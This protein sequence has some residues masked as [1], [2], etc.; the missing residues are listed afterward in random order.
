MH[1]CQAVF[2]NNDLSLHLSLIKECNMLFIRNFELHQVVK[3]IE[4]SQTSLPIQMQLMPT[5]I[6][7]IAVAFRDGS[8]KLV[9]F[10]NEANQASIQTLHEDLT[11]MKVCPNGR[12]VMTAGNRGDVCLWQI[13][14]RIHAPAAMDDA[15]RY[16]NVAI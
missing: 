16:D 7:F 3:R 1:E 15:V 13:N 6:P 8:I 2:T 14:K 12:Y 4:L 9:D 5:S 11:M 10:M